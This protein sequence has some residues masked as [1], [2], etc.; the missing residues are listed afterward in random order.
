MHYIGDEV[1]LVLYDE[2]VDENH[3]VGAASVEL[4][5]LCISS[6]V[7]EWV[8]LERNGEKTSR[9]RVKGTWTPNAPQTPPGEPEPVG[10]EPSKTVYSKAKVNP[11]PAKKDPNGT[12]VAVLTLEMS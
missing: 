9:L 8:E 7:D 6:G 5:S 11:S 3:C 1:K 12:N 10:R 4:S 2:D